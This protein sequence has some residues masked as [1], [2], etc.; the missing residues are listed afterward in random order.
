MSEYE[1][2]LTVEPRR[3]KR[4]NPDQPRVPAGQTGGGRWTSGGDAGGTPVE[5]KGPSAVASYLGKKPE[6]TEFAVLPKDE[7][8]DRFGNEYGGLTGHTTA[9]AL[10]TGE[11]YIREGN[12]DFALHELVHASGFMPDGAGRFLNEG[13]TQA[14]TE[15]ISRES[16]IEAYPSYGKERR[17]V[18]EYVIPS[19]GLSAQQVFQGY[20][21]APH[22]SEYLADLVWAKH[23]DKFADTDDWGAGV[24]DKIAKSLEETLNTNLYLMYLVDEV[25]VGR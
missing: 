10:P 3:K 12:E 19:T 5:S 11:I 18:E 23:G 20:A 7:F 2:K 24:R 16:G 14:A 25:G 9:T 4:Y 6:Y 17:F 1:W 22:K 15:A 13:M 21:K 8:D